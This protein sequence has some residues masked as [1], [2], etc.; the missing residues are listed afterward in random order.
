MVDR[1]SPG[2]CHLSKKRKLRERGKKK[3]TE[4]NRSKCQYR[5][6]GNQKHGRKK[7]GKRASTPKS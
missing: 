2:Q 4:R 6:K 7:D 5:Q 3:N 1:D